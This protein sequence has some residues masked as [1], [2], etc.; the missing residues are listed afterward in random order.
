MNIFDDYPSFDEFITS[1][2]FSKGYCTFEKSYNY[3]RGGSLSAQHDY[4]DYIIHKNEL[5]RRGYH[6][7][8]INESDNFFR[9]DMVTYIYQPNKVWQYKLKIVSQY[10][11]R[12]ILFLFIT[13]LLIFTFNS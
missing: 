2:D 3:V 11:Y 8:T 12:I 6:L 9:D 5:V 13:I 7:I 10:K 1:L 4:M